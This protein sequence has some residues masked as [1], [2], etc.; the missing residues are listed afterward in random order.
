MIDVPDQGCVYNPKTQTDDSVG[1]QEDAVCGVRVMQLAG[2]YVLGGSDNESS[3]RSAESNG[4]VN[5]Y[6]LLDTQTGKH[7]NFP[8]YEALRGEAQ[9]LGISLNLEPIDVV[10]LRYRFTWFDV[11]AGFLLCVPPLITLSLLVRWIIK[12]RRTRQGVPQ[13]V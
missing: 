12:L 5:S 7:A 1:E 4:H 8:T 13:A 9:H 10:Y 11:F 6:F 2:R 3:K